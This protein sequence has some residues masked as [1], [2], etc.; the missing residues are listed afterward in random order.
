M[1][2]KFVEGR[3][4]LRKLFDIKLDN[5]SKLNVKNDIKGKIESRVK[6]KSQA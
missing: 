6:D 5:I 4:R 1:E 2:K 3:V